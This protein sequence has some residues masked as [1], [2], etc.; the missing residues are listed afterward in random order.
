[1]KTVVVINLGRTLACSTET[2]WLDTRKRKPAMLGRVKCLTHTLFHE[3][4]CATCAGNL[5]HIKEPRSWHKH[6]RSYTVAAHSH[7][8][9]VMFF[10]NQQALFVSSCAEKRSIIFNALNKP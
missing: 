4:L 7:G 3:G 9:L 10:A 1:M 2:C 6:L 5:E 8:C